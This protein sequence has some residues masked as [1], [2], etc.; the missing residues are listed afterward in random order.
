MAEY[1]SLQHAF[2]TDQ[3]FPYHL[4]TVLRERLYKGYGQ[5]D[6]FYPSIIDT[7]PSTKNKERYMGL[8]ADLE[9]VE[10]NILE[11]FKDASMGEKEVEIYN[12]KFGRMISFPIELI[13]DDDRGVFNIVPT[14]FGEAAKRC[15][16]KA[17]F[18]ELIDTTN[19][20]EANGNI[21][22]ITP[23]LTY[24]GLKEAWELFMAQT[25]VNGHPIVVEPDT[26]IVPYTLYIDAWRLMGTPDL[27]ITTAE[28]RGAGIE[29]TG[30]HRYP[31]FFK[32][33]FNVMM[34]PY[35]T[36]TDA[37]YLIRAKDWG[38]L[39]E[40][41]PLNIITTTSTNDQV[42]KMDAYM[43]RARMRFG[44]GVLDH[45]FIVKSPGA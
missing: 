33:R 37:W 40:R 42:I 38:V 5:Y 21:V 27:T 12:H 44:V 17:V 20:S 6:A 34:V 45:R 41:V 35:L 15:I 28:T 23:A 2:N 4:E 26:L 13:E 29:D 8:H 43:T 30:S 39:Q 3:D 24:E 11:P 9:F 25:D 16:D 1:Q 31:H 18:D 22:G 10:T 19:Y 36:D 7:V 32:G 14:K